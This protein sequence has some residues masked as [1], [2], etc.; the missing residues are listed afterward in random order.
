MNQQHFNNEYWNNIVCA[1]DE[2]RGGRR[3]ISEQEQLNYLPALLKIIDE[4]YISPTTI[5]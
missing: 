3:P 5:A 4:N 1:A 2:V